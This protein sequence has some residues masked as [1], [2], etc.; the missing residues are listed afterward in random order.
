MAL[1]SALAQST[2]VQLTVHL[3]E[4]AEHV[5]K[6]AVVQEP[7]AG[8]PLILLKGHCSTGVRVSAE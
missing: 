5:L 8:V 3:L 1:L 6:V 4:H 2:R 7:D